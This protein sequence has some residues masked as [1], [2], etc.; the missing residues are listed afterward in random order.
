MTDSVYDDPQALA[1]YQRHRHSGVSS[2]NTTMEEPAL[3]RELGSVDGL[4]VADLGCGDASIAP[5]LLAAGA[6]GYY[7]IDSAGAMV[8]AAQ[9]TLAGSAGRV[10]QT[11]IEDFHPEPD[12]FDLIVSRLALHYVAD[13]DR[14]LRA[15]RAGL[16][17][18]GRLVVTVVHPVITC[19]RDGAEIPSGRRTSWLVDNYFEAGPRQ[20]PWLGRTVTWHHRSI[21]DYVSALLR[22]GFTLT[23][24]REC[25]PE[26]SLFGDDEAEYTRRT[27]TPLFLLLSARISTSADSTVEVRGAAAS[28]P[29]A[30]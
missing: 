15:C 22:A 11:A 24:L 12:S 23:N 25:P 16:A 17:P 1:A 9:A 20:R 28:G 2:P 4:R 6:V 5:A 3:W 29:G 10:E 7:G 19:L 13:V 14:V 27:R 18:G 21:E 8:A 30:R 26:R